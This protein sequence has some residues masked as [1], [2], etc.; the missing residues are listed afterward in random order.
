MRIFT[1]EKLF[2][3][4]TRLAFIANLGAMF[5]L[6][7]SVYVLF[8]ARPLGLYLLFLF[9]GILC[10]QIGVYFG[11]WNRRPDLALNDALKS[12]D[13]SY[14]LYHYT[15]PVS[16]MLLGPSGIWILLPRHA[17]GNISFDQ[18]RQKWK[19]KTKGFLTRFGQEP[20]GKPIGEA[21]LEAEA[22]DRFLEKHWKKE[23]GD[24]R[25][26]AALVFV[27]ESTEIVGAGNAPIPTVNL[28]KAKQML[29]KADERSHLSKAQVK[30][31]NDLFEGN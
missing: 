16:H 2:K 30:K 26:Q 23:D 4:N 21:S 28:K 5:F 7:I 9:A 20:I 18:R 27:D 8:T 13:D 31:L 11:R 1:N 29:L 14:S 12:V 24:L 6:L 22:L 10:M 19:L 17:R 25:V 15:T 3:R